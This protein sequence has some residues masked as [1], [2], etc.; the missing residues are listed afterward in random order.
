MLKFYR[1]LFYHWTQHIEFIS[2]FSQVLNLSK[3]EAIAKEL[4]KA[5]YHIERNANP[6]ILFLDVSLTLV[7]IL[8]FNSFRQNADSNI[9]L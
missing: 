6:K 7:K 8:K 9:L 1:N 2:K 4:E 3:A 5:Q